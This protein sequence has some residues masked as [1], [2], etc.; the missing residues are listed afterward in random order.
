[1]R[2]EHNN[3]SFKDDQLEMCL[4]RGLPLF[5]GVKQDLG[6]FSSE[7]NLT[8]RFMQNQLS[9]TTSSALALLD[10]ELGVPPHL[11][12]ST[13][14]QRV[15]V[16]S[17]KTI[18]TEVDNTEQHPHLSDLF[19]NPKNHVTA[20]ASIVGYWAKEHKFKPKNGLGMGLGKFYEYTDFLNDVDNTGLFNLQKR[21][22][23][24]PK[25]T[26]GLDQFKEAIAAVYLPLSSVKSDVAASAFA[27]QIPLS[28]NPPLDG[29]WT[30]ILIIIHGG[31]DNK[32]TLEF[33]FIVDLKISVKDGSVI[34]PEQTIS[35]RQTFYQLLGDKLV[36]D[37][38]SYYTKY[39]MIALNTLLDDLTT[40][41]LKSSNQLLDTGLDGSDLTCE[42]KSVSSKD[43]PSRQR[44]YP[45]S[46][47]RMGY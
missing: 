36:E 14:A 27:D 13:L 30:L 34:I 39:P 38:M 17:S 42:T 3:Q 7:L 20:T 40:P 31:E 43:M 47:L 29:Y 25:L 37:P 22:M 16:L 26:G 8:C 46:Q 4:E 12:P 10:N 24:Q 21:K 44:L 32:V 19:K 28:A 41:K 5:W 11:F 15:E 1:M 33:S 6:T 2:T 9:A 23:N 35:L 18:F 45:L